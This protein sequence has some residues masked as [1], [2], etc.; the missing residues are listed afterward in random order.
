MR[1]IDFIPAAP[2]VRNILA[3]LGEMGRKVLSA[4]ANGGCSGGFAA[5][6]RGRM[7]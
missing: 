1:I 7:P 6:W 3:G 5:G 4:S 2:T